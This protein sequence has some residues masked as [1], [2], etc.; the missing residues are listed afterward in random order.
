VADASESFRCS[1]GQCNH[2]KL[3]PDVF[4]RKWT[5][6]C[7]SIRQATLNKGPP[8][9]ERLWNRP[10]VKPATGCD[11]DAST[12]EAIQASAELEEAEASSA[13]L[14]LLFFVRPGPACA[15]AG[16]FL[17]ITLCRAHLRRYKQRDGQ[18]FQGHDDPGCAVQFARIYRYYK[19]AS[20]C[21]GGDGRP[22]SAISQ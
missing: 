21:D 1:G 7:H 12:W 15:D 14:T 16:V 18:D 11:Q 5:R 4:P 19:A 10:G 2:A 3:I 8:A 17:I 6:A 13:N 20:V 22:A 9:E